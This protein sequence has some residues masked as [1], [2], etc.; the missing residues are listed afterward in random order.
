MKYIITI[1]AIGY[2]TLSF[3]QNINWST[4]NEDQKSLVYLNFGYEF[5]ITTQIGYVYQLNSF[6]PILLTADYS[7]PMGKYLI[8]DF[9]VRLGVQIPIHE[10]NN[11]M[12]SAKIYSITRKH[13]TSL[14][15]M[16][17][18]GSEIVAIAGYYK[19]TWHVAG[20]FGF[21]KS[22]STYLKHT[23]LMKENF[24][25][26]K[27][28]WIIFSGGH[29]YFGINGSKTIK[30]KFEITLRVGGTNAQGKD[31]NALLPFYTQLGFNYKFSSNKNAK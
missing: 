8:D 2:A 1:I 7:F 19:P 6:R 24:P 28:G 13:K 26:I 29:F 30:D 20:E 3:G 25:F 23:D 15:S 18:F 9:K 27:D 10:I 17:S 5:G 14:V 31:E 16:T 22:I 12:I 21:D 11:F 4:M